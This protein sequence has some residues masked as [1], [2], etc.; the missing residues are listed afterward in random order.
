MDFIL[1][2]ISSKEYESIY[3]ANLAVAAYPARQAA[4]FRRKREDESE[5]DGYYLCS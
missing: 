4:T 2:Y 3:K 1:T 5:M